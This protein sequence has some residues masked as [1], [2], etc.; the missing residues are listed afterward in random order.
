METYLLMMVYGSLRQGLRTACLHA[1]LWS[2]ACMKG[3]GADA[4]PP[5]NQPEPVGALCMPSIFFSTS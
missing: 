1:W 2:T 4:S 5:Y 3:G